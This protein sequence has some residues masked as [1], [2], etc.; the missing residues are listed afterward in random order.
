MT[1]TPEKQAGDPEQPIKERGFRMTRRR[2]ILGG[3]LI[4][5]ALVVGYTATHPMQVAGAIM[6]GPDP[7]PSAF[8]PFVRIAA[9]GSVTIVNKQQEIGQGIHAALAAMIAEEMDADWSQVRVVNANSNLGAYGV[10]ITA[11]SNAVANNWDLFRNAGAAA[12]AMFVA[13]AA[14]RWNVP[15]ESITVRDSVVAHAALGRT[16]GFSDLLAEASLQKPPQHPALKDIKDYRLIGSDRVRRKDTAP[17]TTGAEIYTQDFQAPGMLTAMVAHSPR[18]GGK[19]AKF[20]DSAARAVRGVVD[21]FAIESGVAVVAENTFAARQGRD[22]LKLQWD[23]SAAEMRST[24]DMA[25]YYREIAEGLTDVGGEAF[26]SRGDA[27]QPFG[28]NLFEAA[29][30]FPYLAHAPMETMDCVAQVDSAGVKIH[31]GSHLPTVD[32]VQA[33]LAV[34]TFPASVHLHVLPAGGS[35]GRRGIMSSDYVVECVRI[36]KRTNGRPVKLIWTREDEMAGGYYR[37]MAHHHLWI[38]LKPDG[39]PERW[40]HHI[41]SQGLLPFGANRQAYEGVVDS[42]YFATASV[43]DGKVFSPRSPVVT[44]FWRSVGNSHT[45]MVMEHTIDQLAQ[46]AAVDPAAYRRTLYAAAGDQR[47]LAVLEELCKRA[48]WAKPPEPGWAKGMAIHESFGTIVGQVAEVTM[49][50]ARPIVRGVT[51]VVDCGIAISPDQVAAQTEGGIGYGLCAALRGAVTLKEGIVQE[52]NFGRYQVLR[53]NEMP[54]V[55]TFIIPSTNRPSGMGECAVPPIA[56][57][58]ANAKLK[59][60]GTPTSSLPLLPRSATT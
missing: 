5:G 46:R 18:F 52:T 55:D 16:A 34:P 40:R 42:P 43:V 48:G 39:Y 29:F 3:S 47:R 2:M 36:A 23:D 13:A 10:Q 37:P 57:A 59:L 15:A 17:K 21:V 56:P 4:A 28:R 54:A 44:S 35:F 20:D 51:A 25:S 38:E 60:T 41:V 14:A 33:A 1:D 24:A 53:M 8:G 12:R 11:G 9:D 22:A 32:Q 50:G 7:E 45:A 27:S 26:G 6:G 19:L 31:S 30:D 58:V 49:D